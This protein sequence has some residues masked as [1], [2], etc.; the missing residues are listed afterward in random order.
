[1]IRLPLWI[2]LTQAQQ[3]RVCEVFKEALGVARPVR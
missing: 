1:L 3:E 2:G